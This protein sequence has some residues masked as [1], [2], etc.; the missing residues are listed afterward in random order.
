MAK[1]DNLLP[2]RHP[3][4]LAVE[5]IDVSVFKKGDYITPESVEEWVGAKKEEA[6]FGLRGMQLSSYLQSESRKQG[7]SFWFVGEHY[8][9]R[10][11]QDDEYGPAGKRIRAQAMRRMGNA[12][13]RMREANRSRLSDTQKSFLDRELEVA[14][15][16]LQ[17]GQ[18]GELGGPQGDIALIK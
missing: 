18:R 4:W 6:L 7:K 13:C 5:K 12:H 16:I 9:L 17:E 15:R 8:G 3:D 11:L 2:T 14:A 10:I 1:D